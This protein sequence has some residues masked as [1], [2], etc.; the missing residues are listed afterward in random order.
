MNVSN[1]ALVGQHFIHKGIS[2]KI[3]RKAM[4]HPMSDQAIW[5]LRIPN[6]IKAG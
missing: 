5:K 6:R 3:K 1:F 2:I 4:I